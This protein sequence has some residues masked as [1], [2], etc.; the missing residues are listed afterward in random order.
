M[1]LT[2]IVVPEGVKA[3]AKG[4]KH[5]KMDLNNIIQ[6]VDGHGSCTDETEV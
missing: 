1:S 3:A 5:T 2:T 6:D 4:A